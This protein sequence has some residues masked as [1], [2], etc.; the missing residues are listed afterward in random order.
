LGTI[1]QLALS[2]NFLGLQSK[3]SL[4]VNKQFGQALAEDICVGWNG[5]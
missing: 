1:C 4:K 3:E 2:L 5:S